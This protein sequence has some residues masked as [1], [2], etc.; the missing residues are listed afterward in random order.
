M[1][2]NCCKERNNYDKNYK[3]ERT[4]LSTL[5]DVLSSPDGSCKTQIEK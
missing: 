1:G 3:I 4:N 5:P 2:S